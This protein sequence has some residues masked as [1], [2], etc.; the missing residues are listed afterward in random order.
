MYADR[1]CASLLLSLVVGL[2]SQSSLAERK[3]QSPP[4]HAHW[5]SCYASDGQH[6]LGLK[7]ETTPELTSP[8]K[9]VKAYAVTDAEGRP[10]H[11]C[12]NTV[13]LFVADRGSPVRTVFAEK[14]SLEAGTANSLGLVQWSPNSRWLLVEMGNWW[15]D[16]D[17]GGLAL[18]LYDRRLDTVIQPDLSALIENQLRKH[19]S[20][21]ILAV[22]GFDQDNRVLL[23]LAD[24]QDEGHD[25]PETACFGKSPDWT[26]D[27]AS[28]AIQPALTQP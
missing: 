10:P 5:I 26:F 9:A 1:H 14:P 23:R 13:R 8:D 16:S 17:A 24:N 22:I 11:T 18:L 4:S 7:S 15:Y 12:E 19:C 27:P 2:I 28:S 6:F 3:E 25:E 20:I 21:V